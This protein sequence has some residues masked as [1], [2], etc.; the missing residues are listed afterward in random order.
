MIKLR[1]LHRAKL[2]AMTALLAGGTLFTSCG[3]TDIR[4][5]LVAGALSG[6]KG[7]ASGWVDGLI[8]DFNEFIE[9]IPD[10]PIDTP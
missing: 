1:F 10:N 8:P 5:N 3:L 7:A 4:D 9:A 2:A 6:V